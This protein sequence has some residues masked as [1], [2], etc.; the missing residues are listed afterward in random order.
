MKAVILTLALAFAWFSPPKA[1]AWEYEDDNASVS[2]DANALTHLL[3][4]IIPESEGVEGTDSVLAI[5]RLRPKFAFTIADWLSFEASYDLMPVSGSALDAMSWAVAPANSLRVADL[6][7]TL[8]IGDGW[9]LRQNLDRLVFRFTHDTF[10]VRL[11]RQAIGHG[12]A[13]LFSASDL[14]SNVSPAS[15]DSEFK[16]G[17]DGLRLTV[18][19]GESMELEAYALANGTDWRDSIYL[20]RWRANFEAVDVSFL[21]GSSYAQPTLALDLSGDAF[22]AGWYLEGMTRIAVDEVQPDTSGRVTLGVDYKFS[23]GLQMTL[24]GHYNSPGEAFAEDYVKAFNTLS[25]S[26]GESFLLGEWYL[27]LGL[28]YELTALLRGQL[29]WMQNLQDGSALVSAFL[30]WDFAE[31]VAVE[32]GAMIPIGDRMDVSNL[33]PRPQ[34]EFGLYPLMGFTALRLA[35]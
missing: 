22:G 29:S 8:H 13:R 21:A 23:F 32:M 20:A 16:R 18:P 1:T 9:S 30:S 34:S 7:E 6:D 2:F 14:F 11:G 35:L 19:L 24:E 5:Q 25:A 12:S 15:L 10:E 28:G 27:G 26:A 33:I 4:V 3:Y 17:I 31:N